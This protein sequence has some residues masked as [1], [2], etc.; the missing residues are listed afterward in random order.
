M[1]I[2]KNMNTPTSGNMRSIHDI[3]TKLFWHKYWRR[4]VHVDT[5]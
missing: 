2:T 5:V 3:F 1:Y 4:Y